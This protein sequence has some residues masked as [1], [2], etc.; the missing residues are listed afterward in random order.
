MGRDIMIQGRVLYITYPDDTGVYVIRT[1][2]TRAGVVLYCEGSEFLILPGEFVIGYHCYAAAVIFGGNP[3]IY[4]MDDRVTFR[5]FR[6]TMA[7]SVLVNPEA[8]SCD[9]GGVCDGNLRWTVQDSCGIEDC[10]S[11]DPS[12]F[13][14]RECLLL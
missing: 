10:K 13:R 6:L 3:F 12:S 14:R 8:Y 11:P 1:P 7:A 9:T 5:K 4:F 2:D